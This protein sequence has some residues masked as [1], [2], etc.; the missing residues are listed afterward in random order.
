MGAFLG[1]VPVRPFLTELPML[2]VQN[3]RADT[4]GPLRYLLYGASGSGKTTAAATFPR[5]LF[6]DC[7]G[8]L[9]SVRERGVDYIRCGSAQEVFE[10]LNLIRAQAGNYDTVVVDSLTEVARLALETTAGR[11]DRAGR[12]VTPSLA[13]W[14]RCV[15]VIRQLVRGFTG[16]PTTVVFTALPR[17]VRSDSGDVGA[18]RPGLPGRLADEV[19]AAMDFVLYLYGQE[20]DDPSGE[21][22]YRRMFLTAPHKRVFA[23]DRSG[24]LPLW[25]S[26]TWEAL[27][28]P[29]RS[30]P[31]EAVAAAA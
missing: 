20:D 9:L 17:I 27:T 16:L 30:K 14:S 19:A 13:D 1:F 18:V 26:P 25:V 2:R 21:R 3:T 11:T 31:A 12:P 7:E 10:A 8:G 23:K 6:V 5:P 29:L 4:S 15:Q 28:A 22:N 24:T